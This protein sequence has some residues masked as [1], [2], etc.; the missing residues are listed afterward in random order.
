MNLGLLV[1]VGYALLVREDKGLVCSKRLTKCWTL[2]D[3]NYQ[4]S[5]QQNRVSPDG[6]QC[7]VV[8]G[9]VCGLKR[10]EQRMDQEGKEDT[11]AEVV[12][13]WAGPSSLDRRRLRD[14][15]EV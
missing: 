11:A 12:I 4:P 13:K 6:A 1:W 8:S 5:Q 7:I 3:R 10:V 9:A 15:A 2:S 14:V